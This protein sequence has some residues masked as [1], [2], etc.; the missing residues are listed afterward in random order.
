[1]G[2][3]HDLLLE[4]RRMQIDAAGYANPLTQLPGN[5]PINEHADYLFQ[6]SVSFCICYCDL[7]HVKPFNDVYGYRKVDDVIQ[8]TGRLLSRHVDASQN[9]LGH[10]GGDDFLIIFQSEDWERRR[11]N[12][13]DAFTADMLYFYSDEDRVQG[14]Y[15]SEDRRGNKVLHPLFSLSIGAVKVEPVQYT[16]PHQ[17]ASVATRAKKLAKKGRAI[18]CSLNNARPPRLFKPALMPRSACLLSPTK[19]CRRRRRSGRR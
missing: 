10:I 1:M 15:F 4:I 18:R 11:N 8:M 7:D 2:T 17:I 9:F 12:I 19:P 16:S 6:N 5:V 3:G 13:L 14:G